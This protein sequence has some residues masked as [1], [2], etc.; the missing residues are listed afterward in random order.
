M[1]KRVEINYRGIFQKNLGKKIGSDIVLIASR[2]G[3]IGVF[4]RAVQRFAR[5]QRHP[6]QVLRLC[7][8]GPRRGRARSG[9]RRQARHRRGQH[10]GRARRHDGAKASS[11]GDG[12]AS[13]P[14]TKRSSKDGCLLV[15]SKKEPEELAEVHRQEAVRLPHRDSR[16]RRQ[17]GRPLGFQGRPDPRAVLGAIAAIDPTVIS[18]EA[19]ESLSDGEDQREAPGRGRARGIRVP[20]TGG[21]APDG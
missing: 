3:Q 1:I 2:M 10:L 14:S 4:K 5:A 13:A 9:V 18:I 12:T 16:R 6:L 7:F 20:Q 19:V 15:V 21:Q 11:P 8:P 17:S